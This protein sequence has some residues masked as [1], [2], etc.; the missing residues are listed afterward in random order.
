MAIELIS[1]PL[2]NEATLKAY[3][4]FEAGALTTDSKGA[5][6]LTPISTPAENVNGRFGGCVDFES[7]DYYTATDGEDWRVTTSWSV[8][9]WIKTTVS[10]N[11]LISNAIVLDGDYSGWGLT[12]YLEKLVL[13]IFPTNGT[14]TVNTISGGTSINDGVWHFCV[15]TYDGTNMRIYVDGVPDATAVASAAPS[16]DATEAP[17]VGGATKLLDDVF[18]FKGKVLSAT[19]ISDLYT[20]SLSGFFALL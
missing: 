19:E 14:P 15:G 7:G 6:T 11:N 3:Y 17:S 10:S 12:Q 5:H 13:E 16:Y 4:R 9:G 8:G 20:K 2:F 18:L 1:D